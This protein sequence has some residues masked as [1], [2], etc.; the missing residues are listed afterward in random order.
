M[1][2]V[3]QEYYMGLTSR[4][5]IFLFPQYLFSEEEMDDCYPQLVGFWLSIFFHLRYKRTI[6]T[7]FLISENFDLKYIDYYSTSSVQ[8]L[9]FKQ[10]GIIPLLE[11]Q[12]LYRQ[13]P[14]VLV[15]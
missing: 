4:N 1:N 5:W 7:I 13:G 3:I 8:V 14:S 12:N 9:W 2:I 6:V 10:G 11:S 15:L